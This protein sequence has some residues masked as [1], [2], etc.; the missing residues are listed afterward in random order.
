M[1]CKCKKVEGIQKNDTWL[2]DHQSENHAK[3]MKAYN[4]ILKSASQNRLF[5]IID[6]YI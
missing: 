4:T 6:S 5:H 2:F 3:K 1:V